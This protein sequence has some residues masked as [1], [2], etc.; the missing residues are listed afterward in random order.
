MSALP[1]LAELADA[2]ITLVRDGDDLRVRAASPDRLA[3]FA[4]RIR[5]HK[6]EL[7]DALQAPD[8]APALPPDPRQLTRGEAGALGL[9]PRL[10][11]MRVACG[12][13]V[14]PTIPPADWNGTLPAGCM[15]RNLCNVLGPCPHATARCHGEPS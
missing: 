11:W 13:E 3:A 6:T 10:R 15:H 8:P 14:E 12:G 1:L 7:L 5:A 4:P 9:N 2:G